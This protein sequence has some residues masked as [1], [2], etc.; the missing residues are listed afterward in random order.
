MNTFR[1]LCL[2]FIIG[3]GLC[4]RTASAQQLSLSQLVQLSRLDTDE[5]NDYLVARNWAFDGVVKASDNY[6]KTQLGT[7]IFKST[8]SSS[9][10]GAAARVFLSRTSGGSI[11]ILYI[12]TDKKYFDSIKSKL[13]IST[14]TKL[15]SEPST[16]CV[17]ARYFCS[18]YGQFMC[19]ARTCKYR[20]HRVSYT[21][22]VSGK[23]TTSE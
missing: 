7:W 2:F 1:L 12:V 14:C 5:I 22:T 8:G 16:E 19:V 21:I 15:F 18:D 17:G 4:C 9:Y 20:S 23:P 13:L 11:N 3:Q 6:D 10:L